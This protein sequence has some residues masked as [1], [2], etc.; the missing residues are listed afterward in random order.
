MS[1]IQIPFAILFL[2]MSVLFFAPEQTATAQNVNIPDVKLR[3]SLLIAF[4]KNSWNAPITR[5]E[6]RNLI[7]L[8]ARDIKISNLTGLEFATNLAY[9]DLE[10]N[11]YI[12][13]LSPLQGLVKLKTLRL[14]GNRIS[15]LSPLKRL[16]NLTELLLHDNRIS[17]FSPIAGLID[18]L[19]VY[20]NSP[21]IVPAPSWDVNQDGTVDI[22]DLTAVS[23][24]F[25][26]ATPALVN[27]DGTVD[28]LD[29]T[30]VSLNFGT[31]APALPHADVNGDGTVD[32]LDLV[33]VASH[34]GERTTTPAEKVRC[35][36]GM[37][38]KPGESCSYS[39]S[40][41]DVGQDGSAC[42]YNYLGNGDLFCGF[43]RVHNFS[44][45]KNGDGTW[46][47]ESL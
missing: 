19:D 7:L 30:A 31:A 8:K 9:L 34:F 1:R 13:D 25:G 29:L 5:A 43:N 12:S 10:D 15:D 45:S 40:E 4:N 41:F 20:S 22:L 14:S 38:L 37:T 46:T 32:I 42:L 47:I 21:Q 35:F 24:N 39:G 23:Q 16:V 26:T 17:D 44:A 2:I 3:N 28:I 36:V 27:Q 11:Y 18:N 6:M 33:A